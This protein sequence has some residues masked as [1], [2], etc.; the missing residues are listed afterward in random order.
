MVS[1]GES[2]DVEKKEEEGMP[3]VVGGLCAVVY[4][5]PNPQTGGWGISVLV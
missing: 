2:G 1:G 5:S 4:I 3:R